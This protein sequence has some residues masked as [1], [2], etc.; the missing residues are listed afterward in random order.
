MPASDEKA[1]LDISGIQ[2]AVRW[3]PPKYDIRV[4]AVPIPQYVKSIGRP[5]VNRSS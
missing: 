1:A 3:Y 4:E 2:K 5:G